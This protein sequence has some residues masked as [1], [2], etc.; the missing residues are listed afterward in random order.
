MR[1]ATGK[2]SAR[3]KERAK[4]VVPF[5]KALLNSAQPLFSIGPL[6]LAEVLVRGLSTTGK[7]P[8]RLLPIVVTR[9]TY[10]ICRGQR[11]VLRL[12]VVAYE[13]AV[14]LTRTARCLSATRR[15]RDPQ[16]PDATAV[17][18]R[19]D[20]ALALV[21]L[22][23]ALTKCAFSWTFAQSPQRQRCERR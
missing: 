14:P 11:R 21:C 20:C 22:R 3:N 15:T 16:P 6:L 23:S 19:L 2:L 10:P 7:G 12:K 5:T 8:Y 4:P 17:S 9:V 18:N 13:R 1:K